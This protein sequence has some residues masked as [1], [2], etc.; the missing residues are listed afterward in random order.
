MVELPLCPDPPEVELLPGYCP[1]VVGSQLEP[2]PLVVELAPLDGLLAPAPLTV[3]APEAAGVP[4]GAPG[5]VA[6]LEAVDAPVLGR[7][8][9]PP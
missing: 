2:V 3:G 4:L 7:L 9:P 1:E 8:G 6:E 5:L